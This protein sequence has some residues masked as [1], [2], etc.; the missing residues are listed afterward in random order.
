MG[1]RC[2]LSDSLRLGLGPPEAAQALS[3]GQSCPPSEESR[4]PITLLGFPLP[5]QPV[6]LVV[7]S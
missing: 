1:H 7:L 6:F 2:K 5:A 3:P 4:F